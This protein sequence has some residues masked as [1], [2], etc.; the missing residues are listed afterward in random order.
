MQHNKTIVIDDATVITGS[1]NFTRSGDKNNAENTI[2]I[3]DTATAARDAA[4]WTLHHDHSTTYTVT[5]GKDYRPP[6]TPPNLVLPPK[7]AHAQ[8]P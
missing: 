1:M 3:R 4:N 5:H 7:N 2:I 8:E 6:P